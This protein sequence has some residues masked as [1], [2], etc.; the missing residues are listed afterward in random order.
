MRLTGRK[1]EVAKKLWKKDKQ[2]AEE[3]GIKVPTVKAYVREI[4]MITDSQTR[5]EAMWKLLTKK[6]CPIEE[7]IVCS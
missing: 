4:L 3:L 7:V 1:L 5:T 6:I 2:I